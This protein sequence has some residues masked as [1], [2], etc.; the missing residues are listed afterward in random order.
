[1]KPA[2]KYSTL[3]RALLREEQSPVTTKGGGSGAI[4]DGGGCG[5]GGG[6][7]RDG[8][9]GVPRVRSLFVQEPSQYARQVAVPSGGSN[10][11]SESMRAR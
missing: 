1:M 8:G 11:S 10:E 4:G 7:G 3:S 9:G 6:G 2:A 5:E